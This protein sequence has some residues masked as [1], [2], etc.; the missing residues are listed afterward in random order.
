[1]RRF[2]VDRS[3]KQDQEFI[4]KDNLYHHVC[5]VS[6]LQKGDKLE[7]LAEGVQKYIVELTSISSS[8][9]RAR[10]L[11]EQPVPPLPKPYLHLA[12]S[13]P[14]LSKMDFI[15][16]KMVELGVKEIHP[17]FSEFSFVKTP[18]SIT[19]KKKERW[20]TLGEMACALSGRT[21]PLKI[22]EPCDFKELKWPKAT[23]VFMAFEGEKALSLKNLLDENSKDLVLND[24][25][26]FI[27][28]EGGFTDREAG[29]FSE[30]GGKIFSL[31][32]QILR[33]ET[34]CL[35]SLSILKYHYHLKGFVN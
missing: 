13:L 2:W 18:H 21:E 7:L 14:R 23:Q 12:L 4:L 27:G 6:R 24:I 15:V 25:W 9:A 30:R 29:S 34:A 16:E 28:S 1:M 35:M 5:N 20:R 22:A 11:E 19:Q 26:I 32:N 8:R 31:G 10:I 17:F 3:C 33:V